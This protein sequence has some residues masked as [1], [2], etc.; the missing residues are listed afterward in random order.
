MSNIHNM[1]NIQETKIFSNK[2]VL[3]FSDLQ[4]DL[5]TRIYKKLSEQDFYNYEFE[6][7]NIINF[8]V[9]DI[10]VSGLT[11]ICDILIT[12]L[13]NVPSIGKKITIDNFVVRNGN[14]IFTTGRI[15]IISKLIP[16]KPIKNIYTVNIEV[17]KIVSK[18][19]LCVANIL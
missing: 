10:I 6:V 3:C 2:V 15:Q 11:I 14:I 1:S 5:E 19:I 13:C 4:D 18:S 12:A 7:L 8:S 9:K 16:N 17:V